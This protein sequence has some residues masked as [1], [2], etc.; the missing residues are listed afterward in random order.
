MET[1]AKINFFLE[2]CGQRSDGYH[3]IR[4]IFL[5]LC[6]LSDQVE[7]TLQSATGLSLSCSDRSLPTGPGNLCWRA[8]ELFCRQARI[9]PQ[10]HI[11]LN[12]AIPI[13]AGLGGGSSDAAAVLLEMQRLHPNVVSPTE[14]AQLAG[15]LGADVPFFLSPQPALG[16]GIGERLTPLQLGRPLAV[17]V[18]NPGFPVP[19]SWSYQHYNRPAG[20]VPPALSTLIEAIRR[21]NPVEL[22]ALSWNDLEFAVVKKFP[23]LEIVRQDL[24]SAGALC[25][26]VSGSGPTLFALT[27]AEHV[28]TLAAAAEAA[29]GDFLRIFCCYVSP[30]A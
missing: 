28:S 5:P 9:I 14:L 27:E 10:H 8:A 1:P 6:G 20:E 30:V 17:L 26:H 19:V 3:D 4:T 21:G 23:I 24:L 13:A 25:V 22:A 11:E 18:L 29:F 7:V 15:Q 16:E 12:K 2:V